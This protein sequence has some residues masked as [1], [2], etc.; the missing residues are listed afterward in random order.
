MSGTHRTAPADRRWRRRTS[1]ALLAGGVAA[2]ASGSIGLVAAHAAS[3]PGSNFGS[4]DITAIATGLRMPFYS[5]SGEDVEAEV[6]FARASMQ[7]GGTAHS[8]TSIFWP[9]D[10]GGN[11]GSTLALLAG[12]CVPPNLG[13]TLPIPLPPGALPDLPCVTTIPTLPDPVYQNLN[14]SYKAEAQ[15]G[16]GDPVVTKTGPGLDMV[17]TATATKSAS[18]T[19]LA[20]GKLPGVGNS[21]G[22]TQT[23]SS[24]RFTGANTANVDSIST[25]RDV[26]L[27]GGALTISAVRSVAHAVSDGKKATGTGSTT[28]AGM[29]VAGQPVTLDSTGIHVA[30]HG[31]ALPS[32]DALNKALEQSGLKVFVANPTKQV[33]GPAA[34]V[35]SG[36]L[37]VEFGNDQYKSGANDTGTLLTL[38]GASI[39]ADTSRGYNYVGQP[40]SVPPPS[41]PPVAGSTGSTGGTPSLGGTGTGAGGSLP[42]PDLAS[43]PGSGPPPQLAANHLSLPD[44]IAPA[45]VVVVLLGAG[46]IAAGLKRLPA[47]VLATGVTTC[48]LGEQT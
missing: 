44:G 20:G 5:H 9:G 8:L 24:I 46:L 13:N 32:L 23:L 41:T 47:A 1:V 2:M 31:T 4:V 12:S 45:L 40:V 11:G 42:G 14:D 29:K 3:D 25:I 30:G 36:Q 19:T 17:A 27:G 43:T 10:T 35:F 6:P 22:A 48:T 7:S 26:S 38:G 34:T 37:I 33:K 18:S 15:S 28:I 16:T 21:F 39:T